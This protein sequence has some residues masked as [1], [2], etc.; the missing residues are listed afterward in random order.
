MLL[1]AALLTL[2][3]LPV[4]EMR[5]ARLL[6][7]H[8]PARG[9]GLLVAQAELSPQPLPGEAPMQKTVTELYDQYR[10]L[11]SSLPSL[12]GW[13]ALMAVGTPLAVTFTIFTVLL[14]T[15]R[16]NWLGLNLLFGVFTG[17]VAFFGVAMMVAG[18]VLLAVM[19]RKRAMVQNELDGLRRRIDELERSGPP[20][21]PQPPPLPIP[22]PAP[23]SVE[24]L[25]P[26][27]WLTV[28]TF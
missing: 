22:P 9:T 5:S 6:G 21:G 10:E 16:G 23:P 7:E 13:I 26:P 17:L 18:S 8:A 12:G 19:A 11:E 28:A 15:A 14:A 24:L 2:S 3:A 27:Q 4:E 20:P 1:T 25:P